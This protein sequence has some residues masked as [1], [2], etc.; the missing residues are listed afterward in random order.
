MHLGQRVMTVQPGRLLLK[1]TSGKES[2][3]PFGLCGA[4]WRPAC[5]APSFGH[6]VSRSKRS[7]PWM[8]TSDALH[9]SVW[10]AGIKLN[11]LAAQLASALNAKHPACQPSSQGLVVDSSLRV[12]GGDGRIFALGDAAAA[13]A[14]PPAAPLASE[15]LPPDGPRLT[16]ARQLAGLL[17]AHAVEYPQVMEGAAGGWAAEPQSCSV[18][19]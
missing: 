19:R 17:R 5:S 16:S 4:A 10:A 8:C 7:T 11:P 6:L 15:W 1:D 9:S 18:F 3:L 2:V 13:N 14:S 12:C